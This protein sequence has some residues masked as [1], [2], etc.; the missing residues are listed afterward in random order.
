ML[1]PEERKMNEDIIK[2][3]WKEIQGKLKEQWGKLTD[4]DILRIEGSYEKLYGTIQKTYGLEK[5]QT[6]KDIQAFL[7]K[8]GWGN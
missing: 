1:Y 7:K 6:E 3:Q 4:D 2:G 8:N 5:D